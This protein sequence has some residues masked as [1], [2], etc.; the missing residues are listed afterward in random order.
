MS[1]F[2]ENGSVISLNGKEQTIDQAIEGTIKDIQEYLNTSQYNIRRLAMCSEQGEEF[3]TEVEI[4]TEFEDNLLEINHLFYSLL[5]ISDQLVSI[6]ETTEDK[7]Y[8]KQYKKERKIYK[9]NK[10]KEFETEYKQQMDE[11]KKKP[12]DMDDITE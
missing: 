3:K 7:A 10:L 9:K 2:S 4:Y 1:V 11:L 6:P 5:S 8:W 12:K